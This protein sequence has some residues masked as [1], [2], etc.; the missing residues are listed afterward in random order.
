[1]HVLEA[2][3]IANAFKDRRHDR[4]AVPPSRTHLGMAIRAF[5]ALAALAIAVAFLEI[6]SAGAPDGIVGAP[7]FAQRG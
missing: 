2:A 6:A 1:M 5:S 3:L 4:A 7:L